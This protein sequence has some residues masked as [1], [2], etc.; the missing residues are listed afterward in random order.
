[1]KANPAAFLISLSDS[2]KCSLRWCSQR[3]WCF[4][5]LCFCTRGLRTPDRLTSTTLLDP[6]AYSGIFSRIETKVLY[7]SSEFGTLTRSDRSHGD[8]ADSA[9]D[10]LARRGVERRVGTADDHFHADYGS[11]AAALRPPASESRPT[12]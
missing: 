7:M 1:M 2:C 10:S 11:P 3:A 9:P 5:N 6:V 12:H 8:G 4:F